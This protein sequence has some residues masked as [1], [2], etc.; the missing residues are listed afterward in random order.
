MAS[1]TIGNPLLARP[2]LQRF[3]Q[4]ALHIPFRLNLQS[5][6]DTNECI[7]SWDVPST[8]VCI[9]ELDSETEAELKK[10]MEAIDT[11]IETL[12]RDVTGNSV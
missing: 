8:V 3:S 11:R 12:I 4:A 10:Y 7:I 5:L 1:Y 6:R 2:M 9:E